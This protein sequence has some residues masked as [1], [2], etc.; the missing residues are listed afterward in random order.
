MLD[1]HQV[2]LQPEPEPDR[3]VVI[4]REIRSK[5]IARAPGDST[6]PTADEIASMREY[7]KIVCDRGGNRVTFL[8]HI[9]KLWNAVGLAELTPEE[10]EQYLLEVYPLPVAA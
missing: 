7:L 6:D 1:T 9:S 2:R 10:F 5:I 8:I 4:A 3:L